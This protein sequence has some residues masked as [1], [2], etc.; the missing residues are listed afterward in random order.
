MLR[1][2]PLSAI[3][4]FEA[5]ARHGN[6]TKA[7]EELGMTQAAVSYQVKLLE[8]RVG[9][10]LFLRQPRRVVLS[11]AG[12]R[13]APAVAEAFQRLN[14]AFASLR[15]TDESVLSVSAVNTFCTNWLV[16]RLGTFQM[17]HPNIAVRLEASHRVVDFAME[18]FDVAIRSG[19]GDW[20][21]VKA[22]QLFPVELTAV[23]SPEFMKRA[24]PIKRAEDLLPLPLL[25]CTDECWQRW[26]AQAGVSKLPRLKG[27]IVQMQTQQMI[28]SAAMAGQGVAL[29]TP[30][31]FDTD[32]AAGRL[33]QILPTVV[34]HYDMKYWLVYPEERQKSAKIKAFR[35]WILAEVARDRIAKETAAPRLA[36]M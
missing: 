22:H 33:V 14:A 1:L 3:R 21:G 20:P 13:L 19:K 32:L 10:P 31:L 35:D 7:A 28:G 2:P 4:A 8:D 11:E 34:S 36:I 5:A 25:D 27:P 15:E 9:T 17:A 30:A 26:F 18:E 12:K 6:F 29:V 23:A 16:P 24:G